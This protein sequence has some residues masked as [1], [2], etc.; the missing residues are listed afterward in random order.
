MSYDLFF[1][2]DSPLEESLF[3]EYFS[4]R[5]FYK[6]ETRQAI[7]Q[8]EDTGVYFAFDF[9]RTAD[10]TLQHVA[11]FNLNFFRPHFFGLEA[12][13]EVEA[14]VEHH[15]L[16]I[17]DSQNHGMGEGPF[18]RQGFLS[19]WNAGNDFGYRAMLT[20]NNSPKT[21]FSRKTEELERIWHWN[22]DRAGVQSS[23]GDD[24]FVPRI[25]WLSIEGKLVS[26]AVWPDGIP[27]LIPDVEYIYIPRDELA[28]R[29]LF[30]RVKDNCLIPAAQLDQVLAPLQSSDFGLR[31][32]W[33]R[34]KVASASVSRFVSSLEPNKCA[35]SILAADRVLNQELVEKYR[36]FPPL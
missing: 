21:L 1:L 5:P 36:Q 13:P 20:S 19:G 29:K 8:N 15:A 27:T 2:R 35:I 11:V 3:A 31:T 33:P 32:R 25:M 4:Q 6:V 34:D 9:G 26:M 28:P 24:V 12:A 16:R 22:H 18:S 17:F 14:F 23:V 7:Y 30:S 10:S